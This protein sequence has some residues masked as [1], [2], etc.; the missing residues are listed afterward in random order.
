ML[1]GLPAARHCQLLKPTACQL[2]TPAA[3]LPP[4]ALRI[5]LRTR[6]LSDL[7]DDVMVLIIRFAQD[8]GDMSK[9]QCVQQ[10]LRLRLVSKQWCRAVSLPGVLAMECWELLVG[11]PREKP[12][13][14]A[15]V[16][17][18]G[19]KELFVR[20]PSIG[21]QPRNEPDEESLTRA[22]LVHC[23][24][25]TRLNIGLRWV[26]SP[27]ALL[28]MLDGV[29]PK[30]TS[31]QCQFNSETPVVEEHTLLR[32]AE[33]R[34]ALEKLDLGIT[35]TPLSSYRHFANLTSLW[36]WTTC[37]VAQIIDVLTACP[38][39]TKLQHISLT[40]AGAL[41]REQDC[42]VLEQLRTL[43][44]TN[45]REVGT[46]PRHAGDLLRACRNLEHLDLWD[47]RPSGSTAGEMI[48]KVEA[49]LQSVS[50]GGHQSG[51]SDDDCLSICEAQPALTC[52][53]VCNAEEITE[54]ALEAMHGL[55]SLEEL[56]LSFSM[57]HLSARALHALVQACPT[58]RVL[59]IVRGCD[60]DEYPE[61]FP[62][63]AHPGSPELQAIDALLRVRG[64]GLIDGEE[65][66]GNM[67]S[68]IDEQ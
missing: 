32:L 55:R 36:M 7:N 1:G 64:G 39:L 2:L 14:W 24:N 52:L 13:T 48:W 35:N 12:L 8:L 43:S 38:R 26:E 15:R 30:L 33:A 40:E 57:N 49:R 56:D 11:E 58:L 10:L 27:E 20:G 34:P 19:C 65:N 63:D 3:R 60:Y 17:G 68:S 18:R 54:A 23:V 45:C 47:A 28:R 53:K 46:M 6:E 59:T 31:L 41:D 67:D 51:F 66:S 21:M 9:P 4:P 25:V 61:E 16:L 42:S 44:L 5:R 22:C 62:G 29:M 50:V 37:T